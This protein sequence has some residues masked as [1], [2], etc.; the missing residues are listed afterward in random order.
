[1]SS[2]IESPRRVTK[3]TT[4]PE[5]IQSVMQALSATKPIDRLG[6]LA[7]ADRLLQLAGWLSVR[8]TWMSS[9]DLIERAILTGGAE[10]DGL[11]RNLEVS[12]ADLEKENDACRET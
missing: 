3:A 12:L 2:Q 7:K 8:M 5:A 9:P 11:L 10:E 6:A 4:G 1:M